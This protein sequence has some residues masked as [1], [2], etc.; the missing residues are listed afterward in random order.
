MTGGDFLIIK[1]EYSKEEQSEII[2]HIE[3]EDEDKINPSPKF[4][5]NENTCKFVIPD[6]VSFDEIHPDH[7]ALVS[8]LISHPFIGKR[9]VFPKA[10][11]KEFSSKANSIITRYVVENID[12]ELQ[13]WTPSID[14][15]PVLAFSGGADSTAALALMPENTAAVFLDR[16]LPTKPS[17]S[18]WK[19]FLG[20]MLRLKRGVSLYDKDAPHIACEKLTEFGYEV[21]KMET[22]LEYL[23]K[24]VGFPVDVANS[25]PAILL[26]NHMKFDAVAFGTIMESA[27]GIGHENFRNYPKSPHYKMWGTLFAAAGLPL[28]QVV[29][30]VSEV[31][32]SIIN[33]DSSFG[34]IAHSCMRGKW[35]DPCRNCWKCFRK[36][37]L[38]SVVNKEK[39]TDK[40]LDDL[41]K[42]NEAKRFLSSFPI[43]HENVLTYSTSKYL[44]LF[45]LDIENNSMMSILTKRVRGDV[46][47][48]EWM[49]KYFPMMFDLIPEKYREDI[50]IKL[51][52]YLQPMSKEEQEFVLKWNLEPMLNDEI[53]QKMNTNFSNRLKNH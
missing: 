14:S 42:I 52:K 30:G 37:L 53:Y 40:E 44:E 11:S 41:F 8:I 35:M 43:K 15:R 31:G 2:F 22:N 32:T 46:M 51:E 12:E 19:N 39:M 4:S 6:E 1:V 48:V 50:K 25:A 10:V 20:L 7:L 28:M 5:L 3:L 45:E 13:P 18:I 29:S 17:W 33:R 38:D 21:V 34:H 26:A 49:E 27:F 47:E 36:L 24:P 9:I 23:R 16:P